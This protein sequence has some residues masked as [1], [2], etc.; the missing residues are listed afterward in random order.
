MA[1]NGV[2]HNHNQAMVLHHWRRDSHTQQMAIRVN[3]AGNGT[4]LQWTSPVTIMQSSVAMTLEND[5]R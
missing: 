1:D 3:T 2:E 5:G 4:E